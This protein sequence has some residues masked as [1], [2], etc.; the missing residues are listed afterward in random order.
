LPPKVSTSSLG[1]KMNELKVPPAHDFGIP[2][3]LA[4]K[5]ILRF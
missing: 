2:R 4:R 1:G 5:L 3:F